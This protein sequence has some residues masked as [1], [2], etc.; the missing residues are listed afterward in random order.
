[1][2]ATALPQFVRHSCSLDPMLTRSRE[3]NFSG[4][5]LLETP[6]CTDQ[7]CTFVCS[8]SDIFRILIKYFSLLLRLVFQASTVRGRC[9]GCW[10]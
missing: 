1:V 7:L 5:R 3:T 4:E 6:R 8:L 9:F 10:K 2:K